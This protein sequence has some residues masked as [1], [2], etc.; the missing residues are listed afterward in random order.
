M[1]YLHE[2]VIIAAVTMAAEIIKYLVPLPVPASI[3]GLILLFLLLKCGALKLEQIEHTGGLLL[4]LMPL[5]LV[6]ASVS[7]LTVS[8][9]I[10]EILLPV[11]MMGFA[12]TTAV[13]IITGRLSQTLVRRGGKEKK[14]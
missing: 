12:G 4:E 2:A 5:L 11:L 3:Y 8:D 9:A 10:Q 14:A 6:P 13:M 7:F 1:K